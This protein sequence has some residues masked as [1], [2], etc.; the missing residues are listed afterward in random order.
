MRNIEASRQSRKWRCHEVGK[1]SQIR[2]MLTGTKCFPRFAK[3]G[4]TD[5][6]FNSVVALFRPVINPL[7]SIS[8]YTSDSRSQHTSSKL[9]FRQGDVLSWFKA[10][11]LRY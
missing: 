9:A 11:E 7:G 3:E 5:M 4:D 6:F 1:S 2:L 8:E 10:T